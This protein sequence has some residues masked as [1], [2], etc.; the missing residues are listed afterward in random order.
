MTLHSII[1]ST[2]FCY[3]HWDTTNLKDSVY[4]DYIY[5]YNIDRDGSKL[6]A[7]KYNKI[8]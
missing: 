6:D 3:G 7:G 2:I 1:I 8:K 4:I 5:I